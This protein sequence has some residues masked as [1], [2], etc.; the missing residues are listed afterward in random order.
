MIPAILFEPDGYTNKDGKLMGR[1]SAGDAFLRAAVAS[2]DGRG[3]ALW[4][5][6][7]YKNS[8]DAFTSLVQAMQPGLSANWCR[9][10]DLA[11]LEQLGGLYVPGPDIDRHASL[12]LRQGVASYSLTGIT[13]TT[14]SHRASDAITG[15]LTAPVMPWDAVICTSS[16]VVETMRVMLS[17]QVDMLKWRFGDQISL[18]LP[19]TPM[20]PLGVH[21]GDFEFSD[22]EKRA[23]RA[24]LNI[25]DDA[26][27]LLFAGRLSFHAK[28]HPHAMYLALEEGAKRTGKKLYLI[29]NGW[30]ANDHIKQ[31]FVNGAK[32]YAPSVTCLFTDGGELN[33][34]RRSWA[35]SDVFISLSDNI[36]ETFG[37]TPIE[38][39]AAGLPVV[40]SDWNGYKDT[41]RHGVDGFRIPTY[42]PGAGF[43][44][45]FAMRHEAAIDNYDFYCGMTCQMVS[46]DMDNLI[47]HLT[48]L[49]ETPSLRR[50]MG[51]AGQIRAKSDYEWSVIF[52]RY[53][54]LWE[55]QARMRQTAIKADDWSSRIKAAP[56]SS[57][58]R[59]D[60][61]LTFANYPTKAIGP[62]SY[63]SLR[64]GASIVAYRNLCAD[65]L[66]SYASLVLPAAETV[67][68]VFQCISE[69]RLTIENVAEELRLPVHSVIQIGA[70]T[71]KMGLVHVE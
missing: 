19:L 58:S 27:A 7:P 22:E 53:I 16:A 2:A 28:A 40:V 35:A 45:V 36:Q 20:I 32:N 18:S 44:S 1:Q 55:E 47:E 48:A 65:P 6:S 12:R 71:A 57:P 62:G 64:S 31:A 4:G 38:A 13:H 63:I 49:V 41:V 34:R 70:V 15:L 61:F 17:A 8:G 21:C 54:G 59:L 26:I 24:E 51:D 56:K 23:S 37:L 29:Q 67:E 39:M 30:F 46:I 68:A 11:K 10:D 9:A 69:N 3:D 66:F 60:P 50:T 42:A 43:G 25:P 5:Y 52:Q 14:A 33:A